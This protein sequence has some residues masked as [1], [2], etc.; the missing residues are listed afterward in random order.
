MS[1]FAPFHELY[2]APWRIEGDCLLDADGDVI[3]Q[4]ADEEE[5]IDLWQG[6]V[7]AVNAQD[8]VRRGRVM[9]AARAL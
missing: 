3:I 8:I 6:I 9:Q 1:E 4:F 5:E 7:D 2:P